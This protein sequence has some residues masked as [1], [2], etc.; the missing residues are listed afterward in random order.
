MKT[1]ILAFTIA[2][3]TNNAQAATM[4]PEE[5]AAQNQVRTELLAVCPTGETVPEIEPLVNIVIGFNEASLNFTYSKAERSVYFH[6]GQVLFKVMDS[7]ELYTCS[8]LFSEL[9]K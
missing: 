6:A 8:S 4:S 1:M 2:F 7:N 5:R 3:V 9:R